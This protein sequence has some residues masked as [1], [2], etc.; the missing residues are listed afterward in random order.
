MEKDASVIVVGLILTTVNRRIVT[1]KC[2]VVAHC[3]D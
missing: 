2:Q 3:D 1:I